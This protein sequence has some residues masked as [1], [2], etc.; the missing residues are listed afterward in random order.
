MRSP[1]GNMETVE[2]RDPRTDLC[3]LTLDISLVIKSCH[4]NPRNILYSY[5]LQSHTLHGPGV[6]THMSGLKGNPLGHKDSMS[7]TSLGMMPVLLHSWMR[8]SSCH[9][10]LFS[11]EDTLTGLPAVK[12]FSPLWHQRDY[13][14][15]KSDHTIPFLKTHVTSHLS[16]VESQIILKASQAWCKQFSYLLSPTLAPTGHQ[17]LVFLC[18]TC[19]MKE[20]SLSATLRQRSYLACLHPV[21]ISASISFSTPFLHSF[22]F[23][24]N[25]PKSTNHFQQLLHFPQDFCVSSGPFPLLIN[26][27][28]NPDVL[29]GLCRSYL[30][31]EIINSFMAK[32]NK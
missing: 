30:S 29:Q 1:R 12:L 22:F 11:G 27:V 20:M 26:S 2:D 23:C 5:L 28:S 13:V 16:E 10:N 15:P 18:T 24:Q 8:F 31:N 6:A 25:L 4:L 17:L 3:S 21:F 19:A 9:L 7:I 32:I 14:K